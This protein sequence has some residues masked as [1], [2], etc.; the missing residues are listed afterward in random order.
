MQTSKKPSATQ[1]K[2]MVFYELCRKDP[3]T[4]SIEH[5][6]TKAGVDLKKLKKWVNSQE[7]FFQYALDMFRFL[8]AINVG[9]A[10]SNGD[11]TVEEANQYLAGAVP[12]PSL[13]DFV[14]RAK[15]QDVRK[16]TRRKMLIEVERMKKHGSRQ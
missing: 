15:E 12:F 4:Y 6:A 11:L 9:R 16:E 1:K 7:E 2:F 14:M 10:F 8:C 3:K 5:A 13:D